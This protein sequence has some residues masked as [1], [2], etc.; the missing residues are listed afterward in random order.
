M[1]ADYLVSTYGY[2]KIA[3]ADP[4]YEIANKYFGMKVKDRKLLQ[5]I[6]EKFREID[7]LIWVKITMRRATEYDKV[8]I[9]DCRRK[10]EYIE[11]VI[12]HNYLPIRINADLD[13]RI[14]RLEKRD[15][16]YPNLSL[17]ENDSETGADGCKFLEV[18][19]N[20]TFEDLYKQIDFIQEQNW[21]DYIL[22][23][24]REVFFKQYASY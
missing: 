1:F 6:G 5:A 21:D 9:S 14:D 4:I 3:F 11:T 18:D 15:G 19:N 22:S 8:V 2:T 10:N 23:I 24:Q 16:H 7:P 20:G 17:L 13:I 12:N